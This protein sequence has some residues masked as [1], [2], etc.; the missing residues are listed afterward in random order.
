MGTYKSFSEKNVI[1]KTEGIS[2]NSSKIMSH[3]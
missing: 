2:I 3:D 1:L